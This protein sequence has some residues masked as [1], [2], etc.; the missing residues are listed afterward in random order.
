MPLNVYL[1]RI[2]K[3]TSALC[4]SCQ[5]APE[6]VHHYL[7]DC[8]MWRHER[9]H[10]VKKLGRDSK[11]MPHLLNMRKGTVEV[12]KFVGRTGRFKACYGDT[13]LVI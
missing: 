9:W 6:T 1:H 3:A 2:S 7:V 12:F 10:I 8:V 5:Q 13:S 11:L 4:P